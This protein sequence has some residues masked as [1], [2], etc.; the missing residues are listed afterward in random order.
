MLQDALPNV[1]SR[2]ST[3]DLELLKALSAFPPVQDD[4]IV[5]LLTRRS[6]SPAARRP[7]SASPVRGKPPKQP[8]AHLSENSPISYKI[9]ELQAKIDQEGLSLPEQFK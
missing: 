5:C 1:R 2:S 8:G 4:E 7:N 3:P 6:S 9:R